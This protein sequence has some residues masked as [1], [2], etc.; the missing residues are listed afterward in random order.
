MNASAEMERN[1]KLA[2]TDD[3]G[4]NESPGADEKSENR[5]KKPEMPEVDE[6]TARMDRMLASLKKRSI[7]DRKRTH[8]LKWMWLGIGLVIIVLAIFL[9]MNVSFSGFEGSFSFLSR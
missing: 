4:K 8:Y 7:E 6:Y 5:E 9:M 3:P 2:A 1:P